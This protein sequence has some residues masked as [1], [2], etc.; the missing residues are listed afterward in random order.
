MKKIFK[1]LLVVLLL[2][3]P[4]LAVQDADKNGAI[5]IS[6]GGT[7]ATTAAGARTSLGVDPAGT[8]NSTDVT[9]ASG[10]NALTLSGQE[11]NTD[12]TVEEL[13]DLTAVNNA[14]LG[15]NSTGHLEAKSSLDIDIILADEAPSEGA[16][17][18]TY[19]ATNDAL[20]VYDGS[21]VDTFS[22]D[23]TNAT[24]YE[25]MLNN[26]AGLAAALSDE[27]GTGAAVFATSPTLTTPNLGTPSA[28]TLTN[29]TGL[30]L[31]SGVTGNLPVSNLNSGTNASS[32]TYWRGD[33]T[34][35]TPSGGS[36]P[37]DTAYGSD[38]DGDTDA[39]SK[40]AIYDKIETIPTSTGTYT[41]DGGS[42]SASS[43]GEICAGGTAS[44]NPTNDTIDGGKS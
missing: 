23:A 11:I 12:A 43:T 35:A 19:D 8:D 42:A 28:L 41:I 44:T 38:W 18:I 7:N 6:K 33:G 13:A 16:G 29:A 32:T 10:V 40:N 9:L 4:A 34:W 39:A 37:E 14:V 31:S 2:A 20:R 15:Y 27:T 25:G 17:H 22:N 24:L 36:T 3:T 1:I 30:P 26:S 5:D 21:A